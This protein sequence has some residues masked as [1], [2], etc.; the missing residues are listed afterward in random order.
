MPK[1][2]RESLIF[3]VMMCF[4]MV[5]WMSLYNITI[6]EGGFSA[7]VIEKAWLGFPLAYVVA[8]ILDMFVVSKYAKQVAFKYFVKPDSSNAKK[9]LAVSVCMVVPMVICMSL[10]GALEACIKTGDW[11]MLP[12]I[13]LTN[14]PINF[15]MAL[16]FQLLIAGP[17]VRKSFRNLFPEG[18]V[19]G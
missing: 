7:T 18:T 2:Q 1:N 6:H 14:I 4:L 3:T 12:L 17:L 9:G 13:W 16:P 15:I 11:S 10:Y 8:M 19:L 5:L